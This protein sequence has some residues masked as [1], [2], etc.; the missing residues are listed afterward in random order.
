MSEIKHYRLPFSVRYIAGCDMDIYSNGEG[1]VCEFRG[2]SHST[3]LMDEHGPE[4]QANA[5]F[6][7]EAC[8]NYYKLKEQNEKLKEALSSLIRLSEYGV[9]VCAN[10]SRPEERSRHSEDLML[11]ITKASEALKSC[12]S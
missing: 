1:K 2:L 11:L 6:I 9:D 3:E 5:L 10:N 12:E 7:V 4:Y 8:N